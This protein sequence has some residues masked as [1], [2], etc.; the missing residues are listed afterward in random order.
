[1]I[2]L[3]AATIMIGFFGGTYVVAYVIG[4]A[5]GR[6]GGTRAVLRAGARRAGEL[7]ET[8]RT[9]TGGKHRGEGVTVAQLMG[10]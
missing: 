7:N 9:L 2:A 5:V 10:R 1:M 4:V 8:R 3:I 6:R